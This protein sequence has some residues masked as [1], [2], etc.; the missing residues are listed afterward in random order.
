MLTKLLKNVKLRTR[1]KAI[2]LCLL[3]FRVQ[4][5]ANDEAKSYMVARLTALTADIQVN[6]DDTRQ[7]RLFV[8]LNSDAFRVGC[9][10]CAGQSGVVSVRSITELIRRTSHPQT[11]FYEFDKHEQIQIADIGLDGSHGGNESAGHSTLSRNLDDERHDRHDR[12]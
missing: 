6:F 10:L 11:A 7:H 8:M 2:L 1:K 3:I 12:H 5:K 4:K 9:C